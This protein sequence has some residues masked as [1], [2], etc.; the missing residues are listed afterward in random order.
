MTV[1]VATQTAA[2]GVIRVGC[3]DCGM[4]TGCERRNVRSC[5]RCRGGNLVSLGPWAPQPGL[6]TIQALFDRGRLPFEARTFGEPVPVRLP[7]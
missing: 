5:S 1:S 7:R 2:P 6:F 3:L 4:T